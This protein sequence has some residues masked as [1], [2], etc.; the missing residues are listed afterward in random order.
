MRS[1]PP[2]RISKGTIICIQCKKDK[3]VGK[4]HKALLC[5]ACYLKKNRLIVRRRVLDHYGGICACCGESAYEFL[6]FDHIN[7]GG[8]Q[9]RKQIK[10]KDLYIWLY[11]NNYPTGFQVLCHNCNN[12]KGFYGRCPHQ[13]L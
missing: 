6:A 12:A 8:V 3:K 9:H 4:G 1:K 13:S 11:S 7:G 10:S 2:I 5:N